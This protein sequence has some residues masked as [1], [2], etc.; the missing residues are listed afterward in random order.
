MRR[1]QVSRTQA[2]SSLPRST[3]TRRTAVSTSVVAK[4]YF[5]PTSLPGCQL[6][7]DATDNSSLVMDGTNVTTWRD[8]SGN[9][10]HMNTIAG[11]PSNNWSG[12][13]AYP[14][15]GTSINGLQTVNFKAQSGLKQSTTLDGVK[16]LFWVGRIAAPDGSG[17]TNYMYL[18]GHDSAYDWTGEPYGGK[19]INGGF[20]QSGINNASASLFTN[21]P[22][23]VTNATFSNVFMPSAPNVS[24][25]SVAGIT[26]TTRYQGICYDRET[27]IGWCGDLAEVIIFNSALTTAQHQ[28][29]EGYLAHKWGINKY[30]SPTFPLSIPGCQL[31]LDAGD[32]STVTGT[33][34]VTQW[35]DKSGNGRHLG[36]GAGT[37]SYSSN[38]IQLNSSYMFV[39]SLVDLSKHNMFIVAKG[40]GQFNKTIFNAKP[41]FNVS[42][43]SL[44]AFGFYLYSSDG[45]AYFANNVNDNGVGFSV[46][47]TITQV[48]SCQTS[49]TLSSGWVNGS[50]QTNR[51][52]N[53]TRT[54][55]AR[56]FAIGAEYYNNMHNNSGANA[57][58]YEIL[59]YNSDFSIS[60]RETIEKYLMQK[61][62]LSG[63]SLTH[64][65]YNFIPAPLSA[66]LPTSI[67]GCGLWLDSV[68][69]SSMTFSSGSNISQWK[70]KS[71]LNNHATGFNSPVL[72]TNNINGNQAIA[73][74]STAYFIGPVSVTG[75]TLTVFCVARITILP[76]GAND[77]RLVSLVNGNSVDYG[78]TDSTIALFN[79]GNTST[80]A[81]WRTSGPIA[82]NAIVANTPFLAVSGYDGTNGYLWK[83]GSAGTLASGVS[84]GT[85]AITKY[86]VG[87]G[88]YIG[89]FWSGSIGEVIIY[90]T[91]LSTSER[92][93]VEGYLSHKWRLNS[94][95]PSDHLYKSIIPS[96][97]TITPFL[98]T[99]IPGCALWLDGSD[100]SSLVLSGSNITTWKDKSGSSNHF[101]TTSGTPTSILDNGRNVVNF[102]SG[103]IMTSTN[104][105]TSTTSSAFFIVSLLNSITVA[106]VGMILGFTN[107]AGGDFSIRY[108]GNKILGGTSGSGNNGDLANGAYYVN[109][110][111][112]PSFGSS[113]YL[114][115]YSIIGTVAP[116]AVT[117]F[118]TLSSAFMSRYFI[119]N[120]AEFLFYPGG[121]TTFQRQQVESYL[122]Y[123]WGIQSTLPADHAYKT[124]PPSV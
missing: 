61:W 33:T 31:W 117:S 99:L 69:T 51:T 34:T 38:A 88:A 72:T 42:W 106:D 62:G 17:S 115:T 122:A 116:S 7:L 14:T 95:L 67:S 39:D 66:F 5:L 37:T 119:G 74:N 123:K 89:E 47:T 103:A 104:Q 36:V 107:I 4:S 86:G 32:S 64:P 48:Y 29:V 1:R 96:G 9:S 73:T 6:W 53:A 58:I 120:I 52:L 41:L 65:Y 45:A 30:Y 76:N 78:R 75:T 35:R 100:T 11:T 118:L 43:N 81:L 24:L 59:V 109:G 97:S 56:G 92:Q 25:L 13:P 102:T 110:T 26:G 46:N 15:I 40:T 28:A 8:K 111:F 85:F 71:G 19:F 91:S 87:G 101:T 2:T 80:I 27:H 93:A 20:A 18:L 79:Q 10:Y 44:D 90:N 121:V 68:D 60:Q 16:N 112:N 105:I 54:T 49:G 70:D 57:S 12:T 84:S 21:D 98:P 23:A 3:L 114:N 113:T 22:R 77:Q 63:L 108:Y 124:A 82:N 50:G 83:D 55:T 94:T